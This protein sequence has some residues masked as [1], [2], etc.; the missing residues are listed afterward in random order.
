M[1]VRPRIAMMAIR[2]R[3]R[4]KDKSIA[5]I[6]SAARS[7]SAGNGGPADGKSAITSTCST[8]PAAGTGSSASP[9]AG[10][11]FCTGFLSEAFCLAAGPRPRIFIASTVEDARAW[12]RG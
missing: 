3:L 5:W 12:P 6:T 8:L 1:I 7:A 10:A 9:R 11:G 4:T 2:F